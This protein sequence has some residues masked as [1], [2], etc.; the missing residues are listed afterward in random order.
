MAQLE[1][2]ARQPT[3]MVFEDVHWIDPTSLELLSLAVDRTPN[4][5]L[6]LAVTFRPEFTPPWLGPTLRRARQTRSPAERRK[7]GDDSE[8]E[9]RKDALEIN[10]RRHHRS[11]RGRSAL[12]RG[13]DQG[14]DRARKH[15][16]A[17]ARDPRDAARHA[18]G[19]ARSFGRGQAGRADRVRARSRVPGAALARRDVER[20]GPA[21]RRVAEARRGG[22]SDRSG[23]RFVAELPIQTCADSRGGLSVAGEEQAAGASPQGRRDAEGALPGNRRSP[24]RAR[25]PPLHRR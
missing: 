6:L 19:E 2:L 14:S 8:P 9:P 13:A 18:D 3:L 12:H 10:R 17:P 20:R 23:R 5:P 25:R 4:L 24:A 1:G 15:K 22:A 11:D 16:P 7:R 21:E